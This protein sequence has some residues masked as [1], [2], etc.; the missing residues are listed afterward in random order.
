MLVTPVH[1]YVMKT[2]ALIGL[3]VVAGCGEVPTEGEQAALANMTGR[4]SY[5]LQMDAKFGT[6]GGEMDVVQA[7]DGTVTGRVLTWGPNQWPDGA[8]MWA[9]A[10]AKT[11]TIGGTMDRFTFDWE[12]M[13]A[14][15]DIVWSNTSFIPGQERSGRL[16][17]P[18]SATTCIAPL[19]CD[20]YYMAMSR[21]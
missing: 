12:G 2:T 8:P 11:A 17:G 15:W 10:V 13:G 18:G 16:H 19:T 14:K 5:V 9:D 1:P 4:W 6:K 20:D 21:L 7:A 3:L